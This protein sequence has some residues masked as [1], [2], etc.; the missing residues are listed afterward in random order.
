VYGYHL[1]LPPVEVQVGYH[2]WLPPVEVQVGY[3][4]WLP[5]VELMV[6][7]LMVPRRVQAAEAGKLALPVQHLCSSQLMEE[8]LK[9]SSCGNQY[10]CW[11]HLMALRFLHFQRLC[12]SLSLE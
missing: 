6:R 11:G 4:L 10:E 12:C 3:H 1:W 2:L 5:P 8:D 9:K 7:L